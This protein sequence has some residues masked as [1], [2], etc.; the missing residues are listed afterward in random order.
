MPDQDGECD[1]TEVLEK[2]ARV[3]GSAE[4]SKWLTD[5]MQAC[6]V[7]L[8]GVSERRMIDVVA[9]LFLAQA[10]SSVYAASRILGKGEEEALRDAQEALCRI[11]RASLELLRETYATGTLEDRYKRALGERVGGEA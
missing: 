8:T 7:A 11:Y 2:L 10:G 3:L 6:A 9:S 4:W 1:P 5:T